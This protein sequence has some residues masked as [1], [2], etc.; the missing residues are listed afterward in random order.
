MKNFLKELLNLRKRLLPEKPEPGTFIPSQELWADILTFVRSS[1]I[2][3]EQIRELVEALSIKEDK[4]ADDIRR[5]H[6]K[7][8]A[9]ELKI[10]NYVVEGKE[11]R[12]I[13]DLMNVG[14]STITACRCR[15]RRKLN[16]PKGRSLKVYLDSISRLKRS[17]EQ[18]TNGTRKQI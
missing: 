2:S 10:C 16:L 15:I 17:K 12:E 13:A 14:T 18:K 3:N 9:R 5:K 11:C 1:S 6:P 7:L 8:T 4:Y